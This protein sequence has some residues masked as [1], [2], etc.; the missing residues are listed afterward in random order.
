[1]MK[2]QADPP[3]DTFRVLVVRTDRLG[4]VVLTLPLLPV[5]RQ[6][7]PQAQISMLV[8]RYAGAIAE[9]HPSLEALLWYDDDRGLI[10]FR[11]MTSILRAGEFD[12]CIVVH[13]TPRLAFLMARARIPVRI[14]SGYRWY[15]FLFNRRIFTHR[16]TAER[17]EVEYNLDLLRGLGLNVGEVIRPEFFIAIPDDAR[18]RVSELL[19]EKGKA[20]RYIVVH[21][22][23]GGS[24]RE[25]PRESL[26]ALTRQLMT[27]E[28]VEVFIT[29]TASERDQ[30]EQILGFTGG[31][32]VNLCGLL[33]LKE[34]A[35]LLEGAALYI[36]N[37]TG[38][39]HMAV[40]V[41]TPVLGFYPQIPAMGPRRWG[42]YTTRARVLVPRKSSDCSQCRQRGTACECMASISVNE[43]F[44][45][46][47]ELLAVDRVPRVP[48][49]YGS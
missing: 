22:G 4:D 1:M 29:G 14:G 38:P 40:A 45:A 17:H 6:H 10:P 41:G 25:W 26:G 33:N 31:R 12:A 9:G 49:A 15:S 48:S 11:R 28:G 47:L 13:P 35:A 43:A 34:L 24:A 39:L 2:T 21:P 37:S 42:P 8:S 46:A 3:T 36:S 23:S 20:G 19:G 27:R 18:R 16:K 44:S 32:A 7:F 5:L 30:A